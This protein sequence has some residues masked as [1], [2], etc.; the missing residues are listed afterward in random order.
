MVVEAVEHVF[1]D[2]ELLLEHFQSHLHRHTRFI[3]A[4]ATVLARK[5]EAEPWFDDTF[6]LATVVIINVMMFLLSGKFAVFCTIRVIPL[7]VPASV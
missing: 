6:N 1:D 2:S 4:L 7:V 3:A 5:N